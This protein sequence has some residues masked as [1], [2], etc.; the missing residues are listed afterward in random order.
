MSNAY[1]SVD[2][3]DPLTVG[4]FYGE[5]VNKKPVVMRGALD[6]LP[7]VSRWSITYLR[8]LAPDLRIRLKTGNL[9]AGATISQTLA[10]YCDLID[11]IVARQTAGESLINLP[12]YLHDI[13]LLAL[14]PELRDD[15]DPFP[16]DL[17]PKFFRTQWWN[18]IQ[19]FVSPPLAMTPFHFDTLVTHNLF[20]QIHG[21]K[22]FVIVPAEDR[23]HCYTYNWRW[24]RV[25]PE[26][27]DF[28]KYPLFRNARVFECV[29]QAG[30]LLYMPPGTLHQVSSL[31]ASVSFNMDWHDKVSAIRGIAAIRQGMPVR[32]LQ[33]NSA[34]ALG[35]T[36]GLPA[37]WLMPLLN[38]YLYYIS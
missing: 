14:L 13:P 28:D 5:Y 20:F 32:N 26:A 27:P 3:R 11:D 9:A 23:P 33:Y 24:A 29:L 6:K 8:S 21:D 18:F 31:T 19:F 10:E 4:E 1:A 36:T 22:R 35:V 38:S 34:F 30:D 7:A 25:D 2:I 16:G 17:F 15:L 37:R 12:P